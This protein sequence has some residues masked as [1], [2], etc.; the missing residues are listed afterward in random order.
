[1]EQEGSS[2][3]EETLFAA[4]ERRLVNRDYLARPS[5]QICGYISHIP[6]SCVGRRTALARDAG[7]QTEESRGPCRYWQQGH[8]RRGEACWFQHTGEQEGV[9]RVGA[10]RGQ[11]A[12]AASVVGRSLYALARLAGPQRLVRVVLWA[13]RSSGFQVTISGATIVAI[14][15]ILLQIREYFFGDSILH[16]FFFGDDGGGGEG[17]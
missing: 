9:A 8:C 11:G 5:C 2:E 6:D 3:E 14:A 15:P 16:G 7:V 12:R 13:V 4:A 10:S 17:E 1:V